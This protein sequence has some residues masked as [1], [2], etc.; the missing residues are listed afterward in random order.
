MINDNKDSLV[1]S[2]FKQK[3]DLNRIKGGSLQGMNFTRTAEYGSIIRVYPETHTCDVYSENGRPYKGVPWPGS[4]KMLMVPHPGDRVRIDNRYAVPVIDFAHSG[5]QLPNRSRDKLTDVPGVSEQLRGTSEN[6][7][8]T[9]PNFAGGGIKDLLP[10]DTVLPNFQS[11][12]YIGALSGGVNIVKSGEFSQIQTVKTEELVRLIGRNIELFTGAGLMKF[13]QAA[14]KTSLE[15]NLGADAATE[16][17][18]GQ[19]KFRVRL[20]MGQAGNVVSFR[21]TDPTGET[22]HS[23]NIYPDGVVQTSSKSSTETLEELKK[24]V[25]DQVSIT[26]RE[27]NI[28]LNTV[29]QLNLSAG[30]TIALETA[31]KIVGN[32]FGGINFGTLANMSL[33][34]GNGMDIT[35]SGGVPLLGPLA[36]S[37]SVVATNG[38]VVFDIGSPLAGDLQLAQSGFRVNTVSGNIRFFSSLGGFTVDTLLPG[39]VKLGGPPIGP[40][41]APGWPGLYGA[42]LFEKLVLF[43]EALGLALD[44]HTHPVIAPSPGVTGP[45]VPLIWN[46]PPFLLRG[47]LANTASK[48]VR[49]GDVV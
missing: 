24:I 6:N 27:G 7:D 30:S 40:H 5:A 28:D 3:A 39:S 35:V 21:V 46:L 29:D 49:F 45:P 31:G 32:A 8:I 43:M 25:A 26:A 15:V 2:P 18:P 12:N 22:K 34:A 47:L 23:L 41:P 38:S 1:P 44:S 48:F 9:Q 11:G 42:V 19:D 10:G 13:S 16:S 37:M 20:A 14:G 33:L 36:Q 4:P 17:D